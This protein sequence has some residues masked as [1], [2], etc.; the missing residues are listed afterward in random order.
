ME[1]KASDVKAL[2]EKTGAGMMDCKKALVEAAGDT[3]KAEKILKELGLAAAAKRTG[4]ATNEGRIFTHVGNSRAGMLEISCETDFVAR[5]ADFVEMGSRITIMMVEEGLDAGSEKV[6][7]E[8][9]EAMST[10]KENMTARRFVAMDIGADDLV[11][12]YVHGDGGTVGVLVKLTAED[13]AVLKDG[14]A[15]RLAF[16]LALHVAAFAPQ[17]L[18]EDTVDPA[19][20]KEQEG[21]FTTQANN[22]GKPANVV[23]GIV[24]GKLKKHL[25]EIVFL[26]QPFVKDD[27]QSVKQMVES[28]GK[29]LGSALNVTDYKY[30]RVGEETSE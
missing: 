16:D 13:A 14:K 2:R 25:S 9:K 29:A 22:M 6:D 30:Y 4:R 15:T 12:D 20:V 28:I 8:L 10:I 1:I 19:Y 23:Q 21:I 24:K 3:A 18:S 5:N 17:F 26:N 7:A 27:K 11:V